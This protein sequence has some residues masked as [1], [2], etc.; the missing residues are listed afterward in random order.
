MYI[1]R[2]ILTSNEIKRARNYGIDVE[3]EMQEE[4]N[5]WHCKLRHESFVKILSFLKTI[6][7]LKD[8]SDEELEEYYIRQV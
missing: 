6:T 7:D 5:V 8:Y 2:L 3:I 4:D 1:G